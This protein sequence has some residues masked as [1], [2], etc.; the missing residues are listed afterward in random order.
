M[1][2][3]EFLKIV[4]T[5]NIKAMNNKNNTELYEGKQKAHKLNH[6]EAQIR[7]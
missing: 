5:R 1:T 6:L 2:H 7:L 4:C 3:L